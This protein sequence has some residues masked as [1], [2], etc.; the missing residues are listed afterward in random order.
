M[1]IIFV[2]ENLKDCLIKILHL[3]LQLIIY[4]FRPKLS[5]FGAKTWAELNRSCLKELNE[6]YTSGKILNIY[7]VY[8]LSSNLNIF[9]FGLK[10]CLFGSVKL[11][12]NEN[13]G[14]CKS[15]GYGIGF[16]SRRNLLFASGKFSQNVIIFGADMSSSVHID[17]K[18]KDILILGEAPTQG[19][20][21]TTLTVE[22]K[23]W[24]NFTVRRRKFL[25]KFA[26]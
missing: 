7:I 11:T 14:K 25:F 12:K 22:K 24:I 6:K 19:L 3:M 2:S 9:G 16:D 17:N 21:G 13:I 26:L 20:D 8:E 5:Y 10:N 1:I 23:Y 18:G 15:W 4:S